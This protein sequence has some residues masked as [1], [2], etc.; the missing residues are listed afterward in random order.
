MRLSAEW[1]DDP[2]VAQV[3]ALFS[4]AGYQIFAV[5]GCVRNAAMGLPLADI[6]FATDARPADVMALA[7]AAGIRPLPTGIDH[8][9]VTLLIDGQSFEVT[10][11]RRD[12]ETD[13][14]HAT[15]AFADDMATDAARRDF[16]I[17]ALYGDADG[18]VHD[19]IGGL[20]DIKTRTIRFIG[21]GTA[22]IAEDALR[23]LRFFRFYACYGDPAEGPDA[24]GLAACAAG[25]D[26]LAGLS[27]ER[28]GTEMRKLLAAADPSPAIGA[29]A[30]AGI[31]HRILP[32]ADAAILAATIDQETQQ[33]PPLPPDWR[34]RLAALGGEGAQTSLCLSRAETRHIAAIRKTLTAGEPIE[35]AAY[36]HGA[37]VAVS[38]QMIIDATGG[39]ADVAGVQ[40]RA[41]F[42]A[43]QVFPITAYD[44]MPPHV[45]GPALGVALKNLE[46]EWIAAGFTMPDGA[47]EA[48]RNAADTDP[49]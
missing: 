43:A 34:R 46:A 25:A 41:A 35:V 7:K 36:R 38:A 24:V 37:D 28:V 12:V 23:I 6:D 15:V 44:L 40:A 48:A 11:F 39:G 18:M 22:R 21:D 31:M 26:L 45:P 30:I 4:G 33:A 17:N 20:A 32:G 47:L 16:T 1:L 8:G 19:P 9:T 10:T 27:A 13:G 2:A 5:G 42:G 29:M 14:R 3:F 49:E